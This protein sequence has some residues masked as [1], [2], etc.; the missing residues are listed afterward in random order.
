MARVLIKFCF[1]VY[2]NEKY[3]TS[4]FQS[5]SIL[6]VISEKTEHISE[7]TSKSLSYA[8]HYTPS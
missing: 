2:P 8:Y 6:G 3:L 1:S 5:L 4:G 7:N